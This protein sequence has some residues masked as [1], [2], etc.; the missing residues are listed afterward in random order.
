MS[1]LQLTQERTWGRQWAAVIQPWGAALSEVWR[2][3]WSLDGFL[4]TLKVKR[5]LSSDWRELQEVALGWLY[6]WNQENRAGARG[7]DMEVGGWGGGKGSGQPWDNSGRGH[8]PGPRDRAPRN[9]GNCHAPANS[10]ELDHEAA[11]SHP[12][13]L[14]SVGKDSLGYFSLSVARE[15]HRLSSTPRDSDWIVLGWSLGSEN[16]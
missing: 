10:T 2:A 9:S 6:F 5:Q 3:L 11:L 15:D 7:G 12:V 1:S 13:H 16:A 4:H 8:R 14:D